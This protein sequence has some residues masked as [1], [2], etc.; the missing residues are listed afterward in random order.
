MMTH[1]AGLGA[2]CCGWSSKQAMARR[3][4]RKRNNQGLLEIAATSNWKYGAAIACACVVGAVFIIPLLFSGNAMLHGLAGLFSMLAWLM[5]FIFGV[6]SL[7]RFI[8]QLGQANTATSAPRQPIDAETIASPHTLW[9]P[10]QPSH[11]GSQPIA[12]TPLAQ[13]IP[14][15]PRGVA[16]DA[17]AP[18]SVTTN[19]PAPQAPDTWTLDL[20]DRVEWKRFEDLCCEFYREMNIRAETTRLGAD[21]G[22]DIRLFQNEAAPAQVTAIVQCKAL[23]KPVGVT[24]VRELRGVMAHEQVEKAFFMA[25]RGFT[26]DARVFA[27]ANGIILLD[28]KLFLAML[29]RLPEAS[30][31]RLLDFATAGDWTIPTCPKCGAK[32]TARDSKRGRFWGCSSFPRCHAKVNMRASAR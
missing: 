4:Y 29:Q 27:R 20:I 6:I 19:P 14:A 28:G 10:A 7:L 11:P 31:K 15:S 22:I 32:M 5:A 24:T 18:R 9:V 25:P 12:R 26:E 1:A 30:A 16:I 2:F 13:G 8:R 23:S 3:R 21:G 17:S